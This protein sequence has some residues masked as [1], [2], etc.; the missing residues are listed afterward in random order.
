M[1]GQPSLIR[2]LFLATR[3]EAQ[4]RFCVQVRAEVHTQRM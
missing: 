1:H 3:Q 4:G 2:R